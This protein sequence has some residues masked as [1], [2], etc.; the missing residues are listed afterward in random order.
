MP[1]A[2]HKRYTVAMATKRASR[3]M[4]QGCFIVILAC[5]LISLWNISSIGSGGSADPTPELRIAPI[6]VEPPLTWPQND[7]G[8]IKP[9]NQ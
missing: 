8:E 2:G 1:F 7:S 3:R 9:L 4:K 6:K 5:V